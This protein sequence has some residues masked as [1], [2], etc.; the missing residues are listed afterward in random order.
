MDQPDLSSIDH[1]AKDDLIRLLRK[2][3]TKSLCH[4]GQPPRGGPKV[5]KG[6]R[7]ERIYKPYQVII[8][9][10]PAT[11]DA[12]GNPLREAHV[13]EASQV[14]A[15]PSQQVHVIEHRVIEVCYPCGNVHRSG[16][17]EGVRATKQYGP[18]AQ[19]AVVYLTQ[20]HMLPNLRTTRFMRNTYVV[21]LSPGAMVRMIRTVA[22]NLAAAGTDAVQNARMT[23]FDETG[24][25]GAADKRGVRCY[26]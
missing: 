16:F 1:A 17:P 8:H 19:A 11:C 15:I 13:L 14:L 10:L 23:H 5:H 6:S 7:L 25:R 20:H 3:A 18:H 9:P 26:Q 2:L 24:I 21:A 4:A 12:C 22:D